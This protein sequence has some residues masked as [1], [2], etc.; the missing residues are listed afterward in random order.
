MLLSRLFIIDF[1]SCVATKLAL[2]SLKRKD[3]RKGR[4]IDERGTWR[5]SDGSVAVCVITGVNMLLGKTGN[6]LG[7]LLPLDFG[8]C[9]S[10][11]NV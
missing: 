10:C 3:Q 7:V 5:D 9:W 2:L 4:A 8:N 6:F 11:V 1:F